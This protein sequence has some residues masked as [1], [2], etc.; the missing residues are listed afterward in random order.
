MALPEGYNF[1]EYLP[2]EKDFA[3]VFE[4]KQNGRLYWKNENGE[5]IRIN[6]YFY[7]INGPYYYAGVRLYLAAILLKCDGFARAVENMLLSG[8]YEWINGVKTFVQYFTKEDL[9]KLRGLAITY[10]DYYLAAFKK[11][12]SDSWSIEA[13]DIKVQKQKDARK[14]EI[15]VKNS[16]NGIFHII[17][18]SM[19]YG[20]DPNKKQAGAK[21]HIV[22]GKPE[23]NVYKISVRGSI[24]YRSKDN[25]VWDIPYFLTEQEARDFIANFDNNHVNTIV[26]LSDWRFVITDKWHDE[27]VTDQETHTNTRVKAYVQAA[28]VTKIETICGPAYLHKKSRWA[29]KDEGLEEAVEKHETLNPKLFDGM[30]LKQEVKD[31]IEDITNT[32]IKLLS[33]E[34]IKLEVRDV[35]M[36][37][38]NASYNYTKDSDIDVHILAKTSNLNDPDKIYPKLYNAYRRIFANKYDISFYGIP[39]EVYIEVE[40]NETVSNGSYSVMFDHWIKEPS[41]TAIPEIDQKAIDEAAKPWKDEA[42]ELLKKEDLN[43]IDEYIKRIYELRQKGLYSSE[44]V[45]FS[46]ENLIFKEVRNAGLLDKLKEHRDELVGKELSLESLEEELDERTRR[47]YVT[48]IAQIAHDQPIVHPNG[49]FELHNISEQDANFII[50]NLRRMPWIEYVSKSGGRY[51]FSRMLYQGIPAMK[52]TITG[53]IKIN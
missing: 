4:Y 29:R 14:G 11:Y 7:P 26:D 43:G 53:K 3:R 28:D 19:K 47:E 31:K 10:K 16:G 34:E 48:K 45:E 44:G 6:D 13:P 38:S 35:I 9:A 24:D 12:Q 18:Y 51:D 22:I 36:T 5:D 15:E 40:G 49:I 17:P 32:M 2:T 21:M 37:G 52:L 30:E 1:K 20:W 33:E 23:G 25:P 8:S 46:T 50:P 41:A 27:Y 42:E 39:V